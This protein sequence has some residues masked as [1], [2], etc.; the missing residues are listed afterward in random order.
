M[1]VT[2]L[3]GK[4][5]GQVVDMVC[6]KAQDMLRRGYARLAESVE[7]EIETASIAP[8]A[9]QAVK[10]KRGRPRKVQPSGGA[11]RNGSGI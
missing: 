4:E 3:I 5:A 6:D 11:T 8:V 1:R 7:A 10:R 2:V 9:E